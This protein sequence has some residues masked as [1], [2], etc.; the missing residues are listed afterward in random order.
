MKNLL[1]LF[2]FLL[3]GMI[4]FSQPK[5]EFNET[6]HDF[7]NIDETGGLAKTTFIF[8]NVGNAP[9]IVNNARASCGCTTP[10]WS[11]EPVQP[12][13]SGTIEV[14]YNPKG[15]PGAFNKS[16]T[17]YSNAE[18]QISRLII[19]GTVNPR[20]K[21]IDELYPRL[22]G[23]LRTRSNYVSFGPIL[24]TEVKTS[25]IE[26]INISANPVTI[27][28]HRSVPHVSIEMENP[29]IEP[30]Q[31]ATIKVIY[32]ATKKNT[33]GYANDRI[34][35]TINGEQQSNYNI[36]VTATIKEDF[37]NLSEQE[38]ATAPIASFNED[39]FDF[40]T[41]QQGDKV[42][43]DFVLT[44]NG[45]S[46]LF[47]RSVKTSCGCTAVK[48]DESIAPGATTTLHA[49]FNSRGKRNRQNKTITIICNDPNNS[50]IVLRMIG[51]VEVPQ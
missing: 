33:F 46:T 50:T 11:T 17:V 31:K 30:N 18:P 20:E 37:S 25:E 47:L 16:I 4:A 48:Y 5:L 23:P 7:G 9:V 35:L 40:G 27:G 32:D 28:I 2:S 42:E 36:S 22:M 1:V 49:V 39:R 12:G 38:L 15:R 10:V 41:I 3:V 8:K 21:T 13:E 43:H 24:N 29:T 19:R 14:A 45:K 6:S 44:N 26:F 34:Y 51:N